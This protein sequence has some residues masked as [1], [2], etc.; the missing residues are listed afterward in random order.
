[1]RN[2]FVNTLRRI[3]L[4]DENIYLI[5]GDLGFSIFE[6]YQKDLPKRF[7]NA[8]VAE[9]NMIGVAAGLAL[10]GKTVVVYSIIPFTTMRCFE[11]IRNDLCMQR[12]NVKIV[13]IGAGLHYGVSGCTHH[14]LE[15]INIFRGLP[16]VTIFSPSTRFETEKAVTLALKTDGVCY[17][18]LS[19]INYP[20]PTE[21]QRDFGVGE[22]ILISDGTDVTLLST[23][24]MFGRAQIV[25]DLLRQQGVSV[26]FINMPC[27][28]PIDRNMIVESAQ[29]TKAVFTFEDHGRIGG[30]GSAVAEILAETQ[31]NPVF[32]RFGFPDEY[33]KKIGNRDYLTDQLGLSAKEISNVILE[34]L[35]PVNVN[36]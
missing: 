17:I 10:S 30:L 8:G 13:G 26:R 14:A 35:K 25:A 20:E 9:Q 28:K 23:G 4:E 36:A 21:F 1:M 34:K 27:L 16:Q 6:G 3:A 12:L 31:N 5:T 2:T 33:M 7:L 15:D 11:Q 29:K 18:R 22:G 19:S 32:Y 24:A